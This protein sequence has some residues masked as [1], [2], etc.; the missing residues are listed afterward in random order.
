MSSVTNRLVVDYATRED[1]EDLIQTIEMFV[2]D[3]KVLCARA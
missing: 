3:M 1:V 2:E